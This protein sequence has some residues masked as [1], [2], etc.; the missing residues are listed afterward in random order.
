MRHD[1]NELLEEISQQQTKDYLANIWHKYG[2]WIL[3]GAATLLVST[4]SYNIYKYA[5][6]QK[7][8]GIAELFS[9]GCEALA[10]NQ[11]DEG[12]RI[13]ESLAKRNVSSYRA[14]AR[15]VLADFFIRNKRT[16]PA[17]EQFSALEKDTSTDLMYRGIGA[18]NRIRIDYDNKVD[19]KKLIAEIDMLITQNQTIRPLGLE[20]KGFLLMQIQ[21]KV[22]AREVFVKLAQSPQ[23]DPAM[24]K[25]LHAM[26]RMINANS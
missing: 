19:P 20:L 10:T 2:N 7:I 23:I 16:S 3:I 15:L 13:L 21:E 4:G 14:M 18:I 22:K 24:R 25:R 12:K 5:Q 6:Q 17:R 1:Y 26:I 8:E 11:E 9:K